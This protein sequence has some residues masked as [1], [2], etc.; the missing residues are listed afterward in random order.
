MARAPATITG[1][2][3][4]TSYDGMR[5]EGTGALAFLTW[6][7]KP[8]EMRKPRVLGSLPAVS[9]GTQVLFVQRMQIGTEWLRIIG[10][11]RKIK[12]FNK[13]G[14][15][16][17]ACVSVRDGEASFGGIAEHLENYLYPIIE[18]AVF[19]QWQGKPGP[20]RWDFLSNAPGQTSNMPWTLKPETVILHSVP[21]AGVDIERL[22][23]IC[24]EMFD[25]SE[26][27]GRALIV[28]EPTE[29]SKPA[30]AAFLADIETRVLAK[31]QQIELAKT[32]S[33]NSTGIGAEAAAKRLIQQERRVIAAER[34]ARIRTAPQGTS[35]PKSM[36]ELVSRQMAIEERLLRL[37]KKLKLSPSVIST[38]VTPFDTALSRGVL[39]KTLA[40]DYLI[41]GGAAVS[42]ILA[43]VAGLWFLLAGGLQDSALQTEGSV[44][45]TE[46]PEASDQSVTPRG[47][48][49]TGTT[50]ATF[51]DD[52]PT[53]AK[54]QNCRNN[55]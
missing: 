24:F 38:K 45:I 37:E 16:M 9:R 19:D 2:A 35:P 27:I 26:S 6:D 3:I 30:D 17:G 22:M 29:G 46:V 21:E 13:R 34:A 14:G 18:D 28:L 11:V 41:I 7:A 42:G 10:I 40:A 12:D 43:V 4:F 54:Q 32:A 15:I 47:S 39:R 20:D 55:Q 49:Q 44:E 51:C 36:G 1:E 53:F 25:L 23:Q 8:L 52:L 50:D 33:E 48:P 5:A 31:R